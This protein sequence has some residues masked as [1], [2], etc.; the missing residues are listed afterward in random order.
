MGLALRGEK[1]DQLAE[2]A[3]GLC[4]GMYSGLVCGCLTGASIMLTLFGGRQSP[5]MVR[6]LVEWF[7]FTFREKYGGIDCMDITGEDPYNRATRCPVLIEATYAQA[8]SIL[9]EYGYD[10]ESLIHLPEQ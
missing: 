4:N 10:V 8:K 6:E 7:E 5:P 1:N 3:S 2:A 9:T